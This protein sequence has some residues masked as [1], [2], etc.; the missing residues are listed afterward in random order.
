MTVISRGFDILVKSGHAV[1][2]TCPLARLRSRST[3]IQVVIDHGWR[4]ISA[5]PRSVQGHKA[6]R[7]G[8]DN[9]VFEN[10]VGH[11]PL[12][13]KLTRAGR[14]RVV[15]VERIVNYRGVLSVTSIGRIASD[16]NSGGVA[17]I[18]KVIPRRD[19]AGGAILV[20]TGQLNSEVHIMNNVPF[21]QDPGASIYVN[22]VRVLFIA[23]SRIAF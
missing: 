23:I 9:V 8:I 1:G 5:K 21:D 4:M 15:F 10:I 11:I 13:L 18:D 2:N 19:I 12:H 7:A 6:A 17:V 22:A 14:G 16:G 20:L 3:V